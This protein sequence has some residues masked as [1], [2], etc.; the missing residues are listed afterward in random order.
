MSSLESLTNLANYRS[1]ADVYGNQ[2]TVSKDMIGGSE[3]KHKMK[4]D[5]VRRMTS[6]PA[7]SGLASVGSMR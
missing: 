4:E 3:I 5:L 2:G 6:V 1:K 7:G